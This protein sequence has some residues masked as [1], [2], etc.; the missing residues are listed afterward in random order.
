MSPVLIS[1]EISMIVNSNPA[2]GAS[3]VTSDGSFFQVNLEDG[4]IQIPVDA[5]N[6]NV[7]VESASVWFST[8]NIISAD[9]LDGKLKKNNVL[10]INAPIAAGGNADFVLPIDTGL[11]D[12]TALNEAIFT[13]I[14]TTTIT[15]GSNSPIVFDADTATGKIFCIFNEPSVTINFVPAD[16]FRDI[17]GFNSGTITS[18]AG[19]SQTTPKSVD[20]PNTARFNTLTS[21]L[22]HSDIVQNGIR[23]NNSYNQTLTDVIIGDAAPFEQINS[24]P[25]N[26][27]RIEANELCG[28][29]RNNIGFWL[30]D[31][32][33]NR[34]NT[35]GEY[36][37][38][39]MVIRYN[40][41]L[42]LS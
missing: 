39:R 21:Y 29:H 8:P 41:V 11:Y 36:W 22:I 35:N 34:I 31:Q 10:Y 23:F 16:T 24:T 26:P 15:T 1:N 5:L 6:V 19:A 30:T 32:D 7:S 33:N 4:G 14:K 28:I 37:Q 42:V 2:D 18:P 3:N 25:F 20:A 17:L 9:S 40:T 27:P 38:F 13:Q 12:L